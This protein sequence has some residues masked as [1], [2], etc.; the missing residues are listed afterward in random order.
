MLAEKFDR[1][2]YSYV[3]TETNLCS[4][5][6]I[7]LPELYILDPIIIYDEDTYW[8]QNEGECIVKN[9]YIQK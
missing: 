1:L 3:N 6:L 7:D 9:I 2:V 5:T 8:L 4:G